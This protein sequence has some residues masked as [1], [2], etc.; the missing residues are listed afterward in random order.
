LKK[1]TLPFLMSTHDWSLVEKALTDFYNYVFRQRQGMPCLYCD[2]SFGL[3][4]AK[5]VEP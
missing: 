1:T 3:K 4:N 5:I 2:S